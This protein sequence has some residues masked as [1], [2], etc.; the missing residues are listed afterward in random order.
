[1]PVLL[2]SVLGGFAFHC[3]S[4]SE[5]SSIPGKTSKPPRPDGPVETLPRA[6]FRAMCVHANSRVAM[7]ST[8]CSACKTSLLTRYRYHCAVSGYTIFSVLAARPDLAQI[9]RFSNR[10]ACKKWGQI[11]WDGR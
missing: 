5:T 6:S 11:G 7:V 3:D 8:E 2:P 4:L 10:I 9:Q 1:M